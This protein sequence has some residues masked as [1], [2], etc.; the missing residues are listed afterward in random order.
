M[1]STSMHRVKG[2]SN[3]E[4]FTHELLTPDQ[5]EIVASATIRNVYYAAIRL[6]KTG[7]V[8][9]FVIPFSRSRGFENFVYK[10][11]DEGM[12]PNAAEAPAKV[13]DALTETDSEWA[14]Q[15][16]ARCRANLAKKAEAAKVAPG[17][18]VHFERLLT[19]RFRGEMISPRVFV[20]EPD[21]RRRDIFRTADQAENFRVTIP[22]W[23]T[24]TYELV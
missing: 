15:W 12:G 2:L 10:T 1:G 6:L 5:H 21:G 17:T 23:Q 18:K 19:F 4:F 8:V 11:Q 16:R 13:L 20:Y 9:A 22:G 24:M 14:N 7:E 3:D